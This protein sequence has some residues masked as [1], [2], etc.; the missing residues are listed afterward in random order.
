MLQRIGSELRRSDIVLISDYDKGVCT[1]GLLAAVITAAGECGKR[2]LADPIRGSDYRKYHG[3]SAIT[4]NRL[5]AGSGHGPES[6]SSAAALTA[7]EHLC[8]HARPGSRHRHARQ[9]RHG[10]ASARWP[11]AGFPDPAAPGLRHH[12]GRR[13]GDE[14]AGVG[15]GSG[16]GYE[17]AIRLANVAGGLEVEKIG[18]ATVTRDEILRDLQHDAPGGMTK[19]VLPLEELI[20]EIG[21][22]PPGRSAGRVHQWLF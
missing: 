4:P 17:A 15:P 6:R 7:A 10:P 11:C 8:T 21:E 5:E 13:H 20:P 19:K 16:A 22:S 12:R 9:G 1:P 18:V 3:C 14:H 2:T